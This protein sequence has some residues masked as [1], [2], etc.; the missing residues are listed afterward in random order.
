MSEDKG[1][2]I[3]CHL[4]YILEQIKEVGKLK[5]PVEWVLRKEQGFLRLIELK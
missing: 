2:K 5:I 1:I 3:K 4:E